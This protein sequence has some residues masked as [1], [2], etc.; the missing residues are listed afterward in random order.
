MINKIFNEL[1]KFNIVDWGVL[2]LGCKGLPIGILSPKDIS[3]FASEQLATIELGD[4]S[5]ML[6]SELS[7]CTEIND[8]II[9]IISKLCDLNNVDL[10]LSK[11][12]WVVFAIKECMNHLPKDSLYGLLELNDFWNE[13]GEPNNSP[14]IIQGVNNSMTPNEYYSDK[15]YLTI[16]SNYNLWIKKELNELGI[17][18][19]R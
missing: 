19:L 12:K 14:N 6:V 2:Y 10:T 18:S 15:N 1:K 4:A 7:F 8:E 5:F 9:N 11:K 17:Y 16:I 13:W 3:D